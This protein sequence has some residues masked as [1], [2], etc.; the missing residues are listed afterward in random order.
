[1]I[2]ETGFPYRSRGLPFWFAEFIFKSSERLDFQD[3]DSLSKG[4]PHLDLE[5]LLNKVRGVNKRVLLADLTTPD[6]SDLGLHVVRAIIPGFHPLFMSHRLRALGGSRLWEVP[7]K[8]GY[9][10]ITKEMGDN[11]A[12]HPYP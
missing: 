12:P 8:L 3:I 2:A 6:V 4:D 9:R 11:S 5:V 10:G 7:Q 1:M